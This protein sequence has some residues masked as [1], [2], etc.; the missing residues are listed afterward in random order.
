MNERLRFVCRLLDGESMSEVCREF[1][2]SRKTGYKTA[3]LTRLHLDASRPQ[4]LAENRIR[5]DVA[6]GFAEHAPTASAAGA[7]R[8][9]S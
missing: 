3:A 5:T 7:L 8:P 1:G 4:P 9:P 6:I 2:I